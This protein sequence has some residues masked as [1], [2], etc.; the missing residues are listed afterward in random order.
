MD[1]ACI[2]TC[3]MGHIC[4]ELCLQGSKGYV[5]LGCCSLVHKLWQSCLQA[6]VILCMAQYKHMHRNASHRLHVANAFCYML[7]CFKRQ[8]EW[9]DWE[10]GSVV[11]GEGGLC[12]G[13]YQAL[14]C[15]CIGMVVAVCT[16]AGGVDLCVF[17]LVVYFYLFAGF[18]VC[19]SVMVS[20]F[21]QA[22]FA[23][24]PT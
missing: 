19:V 9:S 8:E 21:I 23:V 7:F 22:D 18:P 13:P 15:L 11:E 3:V 24:F 17:I 6:G 16:C 20:K 10:C 5:H 1:L 12:V 14:Y 2:Q 4:N